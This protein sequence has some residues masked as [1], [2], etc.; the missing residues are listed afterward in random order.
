MQEVRRTRRGVDGGVTGVEGGRGGTLWLRA[1]SP[2]PTAC[3]PAS[4]GPVEADE[5]MKRVGFQYEGTYKW[6]NPH[7]L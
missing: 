3:P 1:P 2:L 5:L 7:K 4:R 6:V